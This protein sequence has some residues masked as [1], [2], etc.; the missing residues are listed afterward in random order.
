MTATKFADQ[1]PRPIDAVRA[2]MRL[3]S[4]RALRQAIADLT[5]PTA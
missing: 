3:V 5:K 2:I 1:M 4:V